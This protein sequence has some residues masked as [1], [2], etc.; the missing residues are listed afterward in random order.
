MKLSRKIR[1][2]FRKAVIALIR[3]QEKRA[4]EHVAAYLIH[5]NK[6]FKNVA[7]SDLTKAILSKKPITFD[8]ISAY[9]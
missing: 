1:N 2:S 5:E 9:A 4:A 3:A 7:H 8:K 6:D